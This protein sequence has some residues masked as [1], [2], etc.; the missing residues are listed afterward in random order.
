MSREASSEVINELILLAVLPPVADVR[1]LEGRG[2]DNQV[3]LVGLADG[4][5]VIARLFPAPRSPEVERFAFLETQGVPSPRLLASNERGSVYEYV[6]GELLGDLVDD[7][8]DTDDAWRRVGGAF[9][10]VHDVE[11]PQGLAGSV[12]PDRIELRPAPDPVV[13]ITAKLEG[14]RSTL[15]ELSPVT[16]QSIPALCGMVRDAG[17][18][19]RSGPSALLH[20]DVNMWNVIATADDARLIDWDS[21]AIGDPRREIALLDKHASLF[22]GVGLPGAFFEG[23]GRDRDAI[24]SLLRLVGTVQWAASTDWQSFERRDLPADLRQRTR[25]WR[26]ALLGQL[27]G[28]EQWMARLSGAL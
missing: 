11:F 7:S 6:D 27:E 17:Q 20:G 14:A 16:C 24:G 18:M 12:H 4:G 28:I 5:R 21:P 15:A 22:N 8:A 19:L 9:R 25:A 13:A 10:A 1:T 2:F 23:Y 3:C 26:Q